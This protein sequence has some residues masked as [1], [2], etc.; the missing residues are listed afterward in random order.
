[1]DLIHHFINLLNGGHTWCTDKNCWCASGKACGVKT[2]AASSTTSAK[3]FTGKAD[4][5]KVVEW[6]W[7]VIEKHLNSNDVWTYEQLADSDP[8]H[9]KNILD[10]AWDRLA[11]HDPSTRPTQ[12]AFARD[13]NLT[14][15]VAFQETL[16]AG[17][18]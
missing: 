17:R 9:L 8:I 1:V 6:I 18:A 3:A 12:A 15:L 7:P 14:E 4:D 16:K 10:R 2:S 5:L 11:V 13:N